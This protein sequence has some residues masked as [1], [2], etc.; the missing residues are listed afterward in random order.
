MLGTAL[1]PV[2]WPGTSNY[3]AIRPKF[4]PLLGLSFLVY[5]YSFAIRLVFALSGTFRSVSVAVTTS[6][7]HLSIGW[8]H[9]PSISLRDYSRHGNQPGTNSVTRSLQAPSNPTSLGLVNESGSTAGRRTDLDH[10]SWR[11]WRAVLECSGT[12]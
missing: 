1:L 7:I 10:A 2:P 11:K 9:F 8:H 12:F 6:P 5:H 4:F 3:D